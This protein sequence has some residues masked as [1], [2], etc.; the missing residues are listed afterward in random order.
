MNKLN[1]LWLI[2]LP[3]ILMAC[4]GGGDLNS[5]NAPP[6]AP[7]TIASAEYVVV[8]GK[9]YTY[10]LDTTGTGLSF[11]IPTQ[12]ETGTAS[13]TSDGLLTYQLNKVSTPPTEPVSL[14]VNV[15]NVS[16]TATATIKF[17]ITKPTEIHYSVI[18]GI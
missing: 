1:S 7:P 8:T 16:G 5:D 4:G 17:A 3:V 2:S 18:N 15:S 10:Q 11:S 14:D 12:P 9:E 13:V 6:P